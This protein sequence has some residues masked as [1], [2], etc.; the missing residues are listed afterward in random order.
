[1]VQFRFLNIHISHKAQLAMIN[2][3][4]KWHYIYIYI[5]VFNM[6]FGLL[7]CNFTCPTLVCIPLSFIMFI[8]NLL[9]HKNIS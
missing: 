8:I 5:V 4:L 1:M 6:V 7:F 3:P 2:M 9:V